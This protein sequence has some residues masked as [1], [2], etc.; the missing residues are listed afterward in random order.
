MKNSKYN[1]KQMIIGSIA[2]FT[3]SLLLAGIIHAESYPAALNWS[4]RM[5]LST[6]ISGVVKEVLVSA[7]DKIGKGAVV[8]RLDDAVF[9]AQ[10]DAAQAALH[11]SDENLKESQRELQRT[12]E[13]YNRTLLA[14][15]DLQVA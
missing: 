8:L 13:M 7:G 4:K 1:Q 5:E 6:P 15:H 14:D 10:L 9:K 11:S 3:A 2:C 12:T